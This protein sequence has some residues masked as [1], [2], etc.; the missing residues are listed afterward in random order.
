MIGSPN[1]QT[2]APRTTQ[3]AEGL[4]RR[5]WTVADIEAMVAAGII[6]GDERLELIGGEVVPMSPKGA[7]HE[8]V[9]VELNRHFQIIITSDLSV[10]QETTL[11]LDETCFLEPDFCLFSRK[12]TPAEV[13]GR[14]VKLVVEV[15]DTSLA[16]DLGRKVETYTAFGVQEVWVV[17]AVTLVTRVHRDLRPT[18][19]DEVFDAGPERLLTAT[20]APA[21]TMCLG[22]LGLYPL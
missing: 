4:P 15:A 21:L 1:G 20:K 14:D 18:G 22:E 2:G 10:A 6:A 12:L 7:R 3:A 5:V 8:M 11:R 13:R 19:Y 9:K 17:D 16:Y